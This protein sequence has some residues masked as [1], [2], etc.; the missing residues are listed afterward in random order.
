MSIS[1]SSAWSMDSSPAITWATIVDVLA[2]QPHISETPMN[3]VKPAVIACYRL[4][5]VW[6]DEVTAAFALRLYEY[7]NSTA[8]SDK[9]TEIQEWLG[10]IPVE[11]KVQQDGE[12]G[13]YVIGVSLDDRIGI[14][15][16]DMR[17]PKPG[18]RVTVL[19]SYEEHDFSID[20]TVAARDLSQMDLTMTIRAPEKRLALT[21]PDGFVSAHLRF[22]TDTTPSM[23]G[24]AAVEELALPIDRTQGV[25][26]GALFFKS[27][28]KITKT[29]STFPFFNNE[30]TKTQSHATVL[31]VMN[32]WSLNDSRKAAAT[33]ALEAKAGMHL[34]WGASGTGKSVTA[35]AIANILSEVDVGQTMVSAPSNRAVLSNAQ[36]LAD[37]NK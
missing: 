3:E 34:V 33:E 16:K 22:V 12:D 35:L 28:L 24:M 30:G 6:P 14:S 1:R 37:W 23:Q 26:L 29:D 9:A 18:T 2:D 13:P 32:D 36:M 15:D 21:F 11:I 27:A 25:D 31:K 7:R 5:L 10:G 17:M 4:P 8:A 19:R 20:G